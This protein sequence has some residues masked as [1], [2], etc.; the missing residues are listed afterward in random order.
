M[1][2]HLALPVAYTASIQRSWEGCKIGPDGMHRAEVE[3]GR[4]PTVE[5]ANRRVRL[6]SRFDPIRHDPRITS[7]KWCQEWVPPQELNAEFDHLSA[8]T[9]TIYNTPSG[10]LEPGNLFWGD[11]YPCAE[12]GACLYGWTNCDGKH[13][14]AVLPNGS[15]W[16]IDSRSSNCTKRGDTTHRCWIRVGEPPLVTVGKK[17]LTCEAGGGSIA[18]GSYHGFLVGGVFT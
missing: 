2:P 10:N 13:L 5:E 14:M 6:P 1:K 11:W 15:H 4:W 7:C 16:D 12:G 17:G 3:L 9:T 8:S 18:V